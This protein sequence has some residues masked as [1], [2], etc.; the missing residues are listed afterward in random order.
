MSKRVVPENVLGGDCWSDHRIVRWKKIVN[1][2]IK[3][4]YRAV[5]RK[6]VCVRTRCFKGKDCLMPLRTDNILNYSLLVVGE[7]DMYPK[8][9]LAVRHTSS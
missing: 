2:N 3:S 1:L 7:R 9:L 4:S 5:T 6:L 8:T